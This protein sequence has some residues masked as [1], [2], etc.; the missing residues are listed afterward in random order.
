MTV[1]KF[2]LGSS[3]FFTEDSIIIGGELFLRENN[4]SNFFPGFACLLPKSHL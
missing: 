2:S 4:L 3:N 1:V